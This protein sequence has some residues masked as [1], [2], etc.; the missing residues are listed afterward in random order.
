MLAFVG[1]VYS[2]IVHIINNE[3]YA[4]WFCSNMTVAV[5]LNI[6]MI[7]CRQGASLTPDGGWFLHDDSSIKVSF[8][9]ISD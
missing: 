7:S 5:F 9:N 8:P 3:A 4:E 2:I 1:Y 6:K